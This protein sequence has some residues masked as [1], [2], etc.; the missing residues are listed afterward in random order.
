M[1]L[2]EEVLE[3]I[4]KVKK[5]LEEARKEDNEFSYAL[6]QANNFIE[7]DIALPEEKLNVKLPV[8]ISSHP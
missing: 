7:I 3:K 1:E 2:K 5:A 4:S 8:Y 6:S